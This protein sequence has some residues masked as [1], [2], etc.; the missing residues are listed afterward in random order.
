MVAETFDVSQIDLC[1]FTRRAVDVSFAT[2]NEKKFLVNKLLAF[3][4][5]EGLQLKSN[6]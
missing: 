5:Q 2:S 4:K 3:E 1:N 6:E